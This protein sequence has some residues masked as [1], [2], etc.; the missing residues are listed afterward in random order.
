[1]SRPPLL[2]IAIPTYNR[3]DDLE[4]LL[5]TL[6]GELSGLEHKVD[7]VISDNASTDHTQAVIGRFTALWPRARVITQ[8]VNLGM[9]GNFCSCAEHVEGEFFWLMGDDDLPMRER[10]RHCSTFWSA[11]GRT[12][13]MDSVWMPDIGA[14]SAEPVAAPLQVNELSR[15]AFGRRVH[16]WTTYLS[17]MIVRSGPLLR[18]ATALRQFYGTHLSQLSWVMERLREGRRFIHVRTP[19]V[20]ATSGN[21]GGYAVIE[22]FGEHFPR[23]VRD[24][25]GGSPELRRL[26]EEIVQ[27]TALLYLPELLW[28]LR[29]AR[30][31]RFEPENVANA[32]QPQLGAHMVTR[33]IL[34]PI[35]RAPQPVARLALSVSRLSARVLAMSER[36]RLRQ[37]VR[38]P[39]R[40]EPCC[41]PTARAL[42]KHAM[43]R[44]WIT[45]DC[46]VRTHGRTCRLSLAQTGQHPHGDPL[47][48]SPGARVPGQG[49]RHR[50]PSAR[51]PGRSLRRAGAQPH[52]GDRPPWRAS[53]HA[54]PA[55]RRRRQ[56]G[57]RLPHRLRE[58]G[59]DRRPGPDGQPG[60]HLRSFAR[61]H[62]CI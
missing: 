13:Y 25:L 12:F 42:L 53:L 19:C 37:A 39:P 49:L 29:Q 6:A 60:L 48:A 7:I 18:D 23:I 30:A 24:S 51:L 50:R 27:R 10:S 8:A 36:M 61:R 17:G 62:C 43:T 26:A 41:R 45:P 47:C 59:R 56:H 55:H 57:I 54:M 2:T 28:N 22:V 34:L 38:G 20:L 4:R 9:D 16:V 52:R 40:A 11:A 58:P 32:L 21:T 46:V 33:L 44:Q 31:G 3:A 14:A 15:Q 5:A 35:S 1:M